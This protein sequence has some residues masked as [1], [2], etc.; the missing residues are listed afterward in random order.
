MVTLPSRTA[1][2][3]SRKSCGVLGASPV[4]CTQVVRDLLAVVQMPLKRSG[5]LVIVVTFHINGS[6]SNPYDE[7]KFVS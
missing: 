6:F 5:D 2:R 3:Q 4:G 7:S 1:A